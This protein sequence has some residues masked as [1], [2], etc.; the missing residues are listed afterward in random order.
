MAASSPK[1]GKACD[2]QVTNANKQNQNLG[3][4]KS[5]TPVGKAAGKAVH[6]ATIPAQAQAY[7]AKSAKSSSAQKSRSHVSVSFP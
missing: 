5:H 4:P 3:M 1:I 7:D 2:Q 6:K